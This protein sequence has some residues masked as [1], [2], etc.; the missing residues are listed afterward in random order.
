MKRK[1]VQSFCAAMAVTLLLCGCAGS[2][3]NQDKNN[4]SDESSA[5]AQTDMT[6]A[7]E[8]K[9][10]ESATSDTAEKDEAGTEDGAGAENPGD[11]NE[12]PAL[13]DEEALEYELYNL[14]IDINN[15]MVGWLDEV[16]SSY[17]EAVVYQEE[18]ELYE[19]NTDYYWCL[20]NSSAF[21]DDM[22]S[23]KTLVEEKSDKDAL[24][25][26]YINL[27]PVM[28]ELAQT[29]DEVAEYTDLKSYADD[30]FAKGKEY[31][32]A[33][34]ANYEQY[35]ALAEAFIDELTTVADAKSREELEM[36]KAQGYEATYAL[37]K[38]ITTAQEIQTAIYGQEID[39]SQI[40][41]LDIEALQPLYDQYVEEVQTV[42]DFMKDEDAMYEEGF[43]IKSA[44]YNLL[45]DDIR[46]SKTAL[47][48]L[49]ERVRNQESLSEFELTSGIPADGTIAQFDEAL[50]NMIDNYNRTLNY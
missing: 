39:D 30:D 44:S 20:S 24:D 16:I 6:K 29:L 18:F 37:V 49:F 14:Y 43:P 42:L 38:M 33:I 1:W 32:A 4:D 22:E 2:P 23:A 3:L 31:H 15:E 40:L 10:D 41:E 19:E 28:K 26:A 7:D 35:A 13:S 17:F 45:K 47:T 9:T 48:D 21:Y 25:K 46:D 36:L 11:E 34:W 27:Y 8:A 50:S 12:E 5:P